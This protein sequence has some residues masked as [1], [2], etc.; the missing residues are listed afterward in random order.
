MRV[1]VVGAGL[2]GLRAAQHLT[3]AG[4]D[5]VLVEGGVRPGGSC[6]LQIPLPC[7]RGVVFLRRHGH[8]SGISTQAT[9]QSVPKQ[10]S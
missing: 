10:A 4:A 3:A 6:S 2:A 8:S 1:V 9:T 7:Q 5:V